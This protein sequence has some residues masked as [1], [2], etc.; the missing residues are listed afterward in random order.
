M[1]KI[2]AEFAPNTKI[3]DPKTG[4]LTALGYQLLV[5]LIRRTGGSDDQIENNTIDYSVFYGDTLQ[6]LDTLTNQVTSLADNSTALDSLTRDILN[7]AT[8][9]G[10]LETQIALVDPS[11]AMQ[12]GLAPN[13]IAL[14]NASGT[15]F[16]V[17]TAI[18]MGTTRSIAGTAGQVTVAN[19]SGV[20]GNPTLTLATTL[21]LSPNTVNSVLNISGAAGGQIQF[22]A[23]QNP[24]SN[25]N[26]FD[27][28]EESATAFLPSI[29]G[30]VTPGTPT[31]TVQ[32]GSWTKE[33][34]RVFVQGRVAGTLA[35]AAGALIIGNLPFATA[36]TTDDNASGSIAAWDGLTLAAG[37]TQI[38]LQTLQN[39]TT[40]IAFKSGSGVSAASVTVGE[41]TGT[42]D[43]RFN[44][45]YRAAA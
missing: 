32:A 42:L 19:G 15:G 25:V 6:R 43:V 34:N 45:S 7:L 14:A 37:Y 39:T 29:A 8:L 28:Y 24:S 22:P 12:S 31:Y 5:F 30:F 23:T 44:I 1:V 35:G 40:M 36:N 2:L 10:G 26:T 17:I 20:A 4:Q 3:I 18:G 33:G 41:I 11:A 9:V 38:G 16:W 27:D 13:L 21:D